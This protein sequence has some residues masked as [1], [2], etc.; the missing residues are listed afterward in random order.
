MRLEFRYLF[1]HY[2]IS[3]LIVAFG[4]TFAATLINFIQYFSTIEGVNRRFLYFIYTFSDFFL[5]IYPIALVFGAIIVF[6]KLVWK[7][8]LL[9]FASF[10]YSKRELIK[11]FIAVF[12]VIYFIIFA[13]NFTQFAYSGDRAV[14]ILKNRE[15]FKSLKGVFFKYNENFVYAKKIDI[16]KKEFYGATLY[17]VK[18]GRLKELLY[19]DKAQFKNGKW[20][21]N[22]VIKK[23]LKYKDGKPQGYDVTKINSLEILKGYYPKVIRL[24]YEGKRMSIL[25]G[26]RALF[27]LKSQKLDSSKIK[28]SLYTK[29]VMP[30]FAPALM[31]IIFAYLPFHRRFLSRAKYLFSTMGLTLIVWTL[32]YSVNMLSVNGVINPDLGQPLVIAIL[33]ALS[34]Y[35][36]IK[37]FNKN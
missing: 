9:A 3:F 16:V 33:F 7:N 19:F 23:S 31:V 10:G 18:N 36:W 6:N 20:I 8:Y 37:V 4:L 35:I 17:V 28:A 11:P 29:I 2:L 27:L 25:D 13:L 32:L 15:L 22:S 26:L 14:S 5:F 12:I 30:L 21:A 1:K 34:I 24:L